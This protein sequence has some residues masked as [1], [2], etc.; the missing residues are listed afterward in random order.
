MGKKHYLI[1]I[2]ICVIKNY[3]INQKILIIKKIFKKLLNFK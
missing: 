2:K 1:F 3:K